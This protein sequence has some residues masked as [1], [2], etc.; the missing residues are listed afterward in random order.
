LSHEN[1]P[2]FRKWYQALN[3]ILD[4]TG[5]FPKNVRFSLA[6]RLNEEAIYALELILQAIYERDRQEILRKLNFSLQKQRVLFRLCHDRRLISTNQ[7]EHIS[8]LL[9][10]VGKMAGGWNKASKGESEP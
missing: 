5:K 8:G 2:I 6:S 3:W 9:L 10:E 4:T 7:Y 1:Y